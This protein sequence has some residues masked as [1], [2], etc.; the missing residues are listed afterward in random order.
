MMKNSKESVPYHFP[1]LQPVVKALEDAAYSSGY[2]LGQVFSDWLAI[3]EITLR[4]L[5][6]N[7]ASIAVHGTFA[8]DSAED[9][10]T[11]ARLH[12]NYGKSF[13]ELQRAFIALLEV[14]NPSLNIV[15]KPFNQ[16]AKNMVEIRDYLGP[17]FEFLGKSNA[18]LGQFFTP[19]AICE[20]MSSLVM[21]DKEDAVYR[22]ME[23]ALTHH[24]LAGIFF[25]TTEGWITNETAEAIAYQFL[26]QVLSHYSPPT[27]CDP[28]VG[29]GGLLL[30]AANQVPLWILHA[31]LLQFWGIDI[32]YDCVLMTKINIMLFGLNGWG[33]RYTAAMDLLVQRQEIIEKQNKS[34]GNIAEETLE[35]KT[36]DEK[37]IEESHHA[38]ERTQNFFPKHP[39]INTLPQGV[40][41]HGNT[42]EGFI[43]G[44]TWNEVVEELQQETQQQEKQQKDEQQKDEQQREQQEGVD[45]KVTAPPTTVPPF[46]ITEEY[47]IPEIGIGEQGKLF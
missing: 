39:F 46:T 9:A 45:T 34:D 12:K 35:E 30:A 27:V 37:N 17:L 40:I 25:P 13:I 4:M 38:D 20:L 36:N 5:P 29:S 23:K 33:A 19:E 1:E 3:T 7:A 11:F 41:Q 31:G 28:C 26:P 14:A 47:H 2:E 10:E 42:I 22:E 18:R 6:A 8:K 24:P 15:G 43:Y 21:I 16:A 44:S 32:S